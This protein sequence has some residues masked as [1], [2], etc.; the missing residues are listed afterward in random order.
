MVKDNQKIRDEV[1]KAFFAVS[2]NIYRRNI[3]RDWG[4]HISKEDEKERQRVII[5]CEE[6]VLKGLD[7]LRDIKKEYPEDYS[8]YLNIT[9]SE[10]K[11]WVDYA[12][13]KGFEKDMLFKVE[14]N[15]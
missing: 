7:R 12:K 1:A 5:E 2:A 9:C 10:N 14:S 8:S 3:N 11:E 6:G 13:E 4:K 15:V